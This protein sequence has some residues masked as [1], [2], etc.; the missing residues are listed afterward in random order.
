MPYKKG[1]P[2]V[3]IQTSNRCV[4][5][6]AQSLFYGVDQY[7]K[8]LA[9]EVFISLSDFLSWASLQWDNEKFVENRLLF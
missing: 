5:V 8:P 3:L 2:W 4:Q 9:V 1:T 6:G 7:L